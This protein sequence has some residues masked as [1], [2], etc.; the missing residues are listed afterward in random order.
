MPPRKFLPVESYKTQENNNRL[1]HVHFSQRTVTMDDT[2]LITL[3]RV[4]KMKRGWPAALV[5]ALGLFSRASIGCSQS[6]QRQP[7]QQRHRETCH[8]AAQQQASLC[9]SPRVKL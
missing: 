2:I 9:M 7:N 5:S 8:I 1:Q 4:I 3:A 6:K